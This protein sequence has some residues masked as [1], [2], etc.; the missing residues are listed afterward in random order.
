MLIE[1]VKPTLLVLGLLILTSCSSVKPIEVQYQPAD[2]VPLNLPAVDQLQ[3]DA[4]TWYIITETN[5]EE[6]FEKLEKKKFDPVLY[7]LT[8]KDYEALTLNIT[9]IMKLVRQQKSIIAAY[10]KYYEAQYQEIDDTNKTNK[11]MME[12][13]EKQNKAAEEAGLFNKLQNILGK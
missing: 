2:R 5:G 8:D 6:V 9:K 13:A 12:E 11:K 3:L 4:I 10:K 1:R 7:G